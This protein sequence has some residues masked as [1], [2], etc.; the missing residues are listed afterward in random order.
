MDGGWSAVIGPW[1]V[2]WCGRLCSNI[3]FTPVISL[4]I[5]E[6]QDKEEQRPKPAAVTAPQAV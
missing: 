4:A 1:G 2:G 3:G 5:S 6:G